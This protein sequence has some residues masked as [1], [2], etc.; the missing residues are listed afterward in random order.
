MDFKR[1]IEIQ[2]NINKTIKESIINILRVILYPFY[3]INKFIGK[4]KDEITDN[5]MNWKISRL[6]DE[7]VLKKLSVILAKDIIRSRDKEV[8]ISNAE[9]TD[10]ENRLLYPTMF[11][12]AMLKFERLNK[13]AY[14]K[15]L[16]NKIKRKSDKEI[17]KIN[18]DFTE[19]VINKMKEKGF[20]VQ[21][22]DSPRDGRYWYFKN[23]G[24]QVIFKM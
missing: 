12:Y 2:D 15:Y 21:V 4:I 7:K 18:L 6:N 9:Y 23:F 11:R 14:Y 22:L 19:L 13:K 8:E 1:R 17:L 20:N 24:N 5:I 10:Y 16:E 3:L